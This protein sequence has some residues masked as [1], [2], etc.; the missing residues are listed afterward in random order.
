MTGLASVGHI[1]ASLRSA[2]LRAIRVIQ[3]SAASR[4]HGAQQSTLDLSCKQNR[5][6]EPWVSVDEVAQHLD[7]AKDSIYRWN[8]RRGLPMLH[9]RQMRACLAPLKI[10]GC[11]AGA[12][13]TPL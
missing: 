8:D 4:L 7:V 1:P 2:I 13:R 3:N 12:K 6:T 9:S 5:M 10:V 11:Q